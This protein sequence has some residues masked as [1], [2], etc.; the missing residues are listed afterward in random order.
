MTRRE[1]LRMSQEWVRILSMATT[2]IDVLLLVF[3]YIQMEHRRASFS[4][5]W[6]LVIRIE[7][8]T[9]MFDDG[10]HKRKDNV[11]LQLHTIA[12]LVLTVVYGSGILCRYSYQIEVMIQ[13]S[14]PL[15]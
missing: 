9:W 5:K 10:F 4:T 12:V 7:R 15:T 13:H 11:S 3:A 2:S 14:N 8:Y 6:F 1:G